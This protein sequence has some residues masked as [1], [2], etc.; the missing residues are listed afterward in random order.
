MLITRMMIWLIM[1]LMIVITMTL[2]MV[3]LILVMLIMMTM[4]TTVVSLPGALLKH[5][6]CFLSVL[7][8]TVQY[9]S[10][11]LYSFL[12][13]FCSFNTFW[14]ILSSHDRCSISLLLYI[15]PL[16]CVSSRSRSKIGW[17]SCHG[18]APSL[19]HGGLSKLVWETVSNQLLFVFVQ[20]QPSCHCGLWRR[21]SGVEL[22]I[23]FS[24]YDG[25]T[26]QASYSILEIHIL[27][28]SIHVCFL[29]DLYCPS[30]ISSSR[31]WERGRGG[32]SSSQPSFSSGK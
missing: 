14:Y 31:S 12:F 1:M 17:C 22:K 10:S 27:H 29:W 32:S 3:T 21:W 16:F 18:V 30:D 26:G 13:L 20:L 5:S 6:G 4:T 7:P 2:I 9:F 11:V 25:Y 19:F 15:A 8:W 28:F 23:H 24:E